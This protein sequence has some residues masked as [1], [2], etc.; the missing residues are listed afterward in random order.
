MEIREW[1]TILSVIALIVGWFTNSWLNRRNEIAKECLK[2]RMDTLRSIVELLSDIQ[3]SIDNKKGDITHL[4]KQISDIS[5]K[6]DIYG[7]EDE[8]K[9]WKLF[10]KAINEK[11]KTE[12][13]LND[14]LALVKSRIRNELH[15]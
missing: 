14:V 12:Q 15:I 2:Y 4:R 10:I 7:K 9:Y 6:F 1:I 5:Y 8:Q 13:P 3:D 11:G